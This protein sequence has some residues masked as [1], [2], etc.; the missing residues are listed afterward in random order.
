MRPVITP[1]AGAPYRCGDRIRG[2]TGYGH[3]A[4][5]VGSV[6][7][8]RAGPYARSRSRGGKRP[9]YWAP[10]RYGDWAAAGQFVPI[11]AGGVGAGAARAGLGRARRRHRVVAPPFGRA[12]RGPLACVSGCAGWLCPWRAHSHAG[13]L[14][15]LVPSVVFVISAF[16]SCGAARALDQRAAAFTSSLPAALCVPCWSCCCSCCA[17]RLLPLFARRA[18]P[19][20][21]VVGP[22]WMPV[23]SGESAAP[24]RTTLSR[25]GSGP[26][27][28]ALRRVAL[29]VAHV[30]GDGGQPRAVTAPTGPSDRAQVD[31]LQAA[32]TSAFA[33]EAPVARGARPVPG[34]V[35]DSQPRPRPGQGSRRPTARGERDPPARARGCPC[36]RPHVERHQARRHAGGAA[37]WYPWLR[38]RLPRAG[39]DAPTRG[40]GQQPDR[41]LAGTFQP[42][43]TSGAVRPPSCAPC[44]PRA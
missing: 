37:E 14:L 10:G 41:F 23:G 25:L 22:Q 13:V 2:V 36:R 16:A 28:R 42:C 19:F 5:P 27:G 30:A 17:V 21:A 34:D 31:Q 15:V 26:Q 40:A 4:A 6:P 12:D 39:P 32:P 44:S 33:R 38:G 24:I 8:R 18:A 3:Q 35:R 29:V 20:A 9:G 7:V 1:A 11:C 43:G